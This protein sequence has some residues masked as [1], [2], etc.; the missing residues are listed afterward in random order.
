[1]QIYSDSFFG[2]PSVKGWLDIK[3]RD[4]RYKTV[5]SQEMD[6]EVSC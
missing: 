4:A 3:D 6:Y 5:F 1:M 2:E